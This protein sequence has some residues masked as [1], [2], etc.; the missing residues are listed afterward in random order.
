MQ[1]ATAMLGPVLALVLWTL[2]MQVWMYA[3]RLPAIRAANMRLSRH[4]P[5]GEQMAELPPSVRWKADNYNH[6]LEQ[7]TL[8]YA[9]ALALAVLGDASLLSLTLAWAYVATRI[10][11]SLQQALVNYIPVR[12]MIFSIAS[13]ILLGLAARA[14]LAIW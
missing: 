13:L 14:V 12:F 7:P 10:V 5:R 4:R 3:T 2:F 1:P 8:F 6:L 11:H 9:V